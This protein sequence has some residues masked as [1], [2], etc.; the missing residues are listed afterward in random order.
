MIADVDQSIA[1]IASPPGRGLRGVIR[2]SG[3]DIADQLSTCFQADCGTPLTR[4]TR[5]CVIR[6]EFLTG[7]PLVRVPVDLLY[8]P[9][10]ASYTRQRS[11][12][13][14]TTGSVPLLSE[15]MRT[16]HQHGI[17]QARPG[18]FTLR[19]F[20]AGRL[21]L[22]RAE[23]VLGVIDA[24]SQQEVEVALKQLCGGLSGPI[25]QLRDQ[26][27]GL[28]AQIEAGLDFADEDIEFISQAEI[29]RQL[30]NAHALL[31]DTVHQMGQRQWQQ[32]RYR[33]VLVGRPNVGKSCLLNALVG[34]PAALVSHQAGTTRDYVIGTLE[35][36]G[37]TLELMDTAGLTESA[38]G[39]YRGDAV[40]E[41]IQDAAQIASNE[42][43]RTAH[44]RLFCVDASRRLD[45][46]ERDALAVDDK[47]LIVQTK[48]DL[49]VYQSIDG[50][51][52]VSSVS[53][54]GLAEL[55]RAIFGRL[56]G[57][58]ES[59]SQMVQSTATRCRESLLRAQLELVEAEALARSAAGDEIVAASLRGIL[60]ELA[61]VS[62]R[63]YTDDVLDQVFSRFCIGK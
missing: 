31:D 34:Q 5:R 55:R 12:E 26:L 13:I 30:A 57:S 7:P 59:T 41:R 47:T 32:H 60:D 45:P 8:W 61:V 51:I 16:L 6:G 38:K 40:D 14:H 48:C 44:L 53:G 28:L 11:A 29:V 36:S 33:V 1:A 3:P 27:L 10:A 9:T 21:D 52:Q 22:F 23:A 2:I 43:S 25:D 50:A 56:A 15:L 17:R 20:L 4:V 37:I 54:L 42:L 19:A 35:E 24:T 62:G 58:A 18:E 63:I 46:W 39:R 49:P